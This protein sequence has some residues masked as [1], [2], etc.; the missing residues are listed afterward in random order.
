MTSRDSIKVV[1]RIRPENAIET[2]GAYKHC[3]K[4]NEYD[5]SVNVSQIRIQTNLFYFQFSVIRLPKLVKW[6][7]LISLRSIECLVL[8]PRKPT[9][10]KKLQYPLSMASLMA[11]MEQFSATDKLEV[12]SPSPWRVAVFMI[13]WLKGWSQECLSISLRKL[14]LPTKPLNST[15][16]VVT[17]KFT[18][19]EF[20]TCLMVGTHPLI[21]N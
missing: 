21:L 1:C 5:I 12:E 19:K 15:S 13:Q 2:S 8:R 4:H 20:V 17:W 9:Y 11:I 6:R 18:W 16:S 14:K 10:S 3:V 7:V